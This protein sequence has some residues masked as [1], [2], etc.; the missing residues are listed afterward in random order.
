MGFEPVRLPVADGGMERQP[1]HLRLRSQHLRR[2]QEQGRDDRRDLHD[3]PADPTESSYQTLVAPFA[4]Q[5]APNLTKCASAG[6]FYQASDANDIQVAINAL[7]A[8]ATGHGV[9]TQ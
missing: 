3:L 6:Y 2:A 7:F 5:L 4:S 1:L 8:K 9:L